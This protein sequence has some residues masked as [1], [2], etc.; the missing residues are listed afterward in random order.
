MSR[1]EIEDYTKSGHVL[2]WPNIRKPQCPDGYYSA[3]C[4]EQK[5]DDPILFIEGDMYIVGIVPV[6]KIGESPLK[7]G[8][9]KQGGLEIVEALRYGLNQNKAD[10]DRP[11]KGNVGL[12]VIDSCDDPQII[13][14]KILTLHRRGANVDGQYIP[15]TEKNT[16]KILGYVGGWSS[17]VSTAVAS[18]TTR[19]NH[20]QISYAS[21]SAELSRRSIFPNFLRIPSSDTKQAETIIDIV[22]T[23]GGNFIQILYSET[24][25]GEGGRD[26]VRALATR[27]SN[28]ICVAKE[29]PVNLHSTPEEIVKEL[30][31]EPGAKFVVTFVASSHIEFVTSFLNNGLKRNEF[32][33][34]ASE[35]W[36]KRP[37][38]TGFTNLVGSIT[39]TSE[40]TLDENFN[41]HLASLRP[42]GSS[43][44]PWVREYMEYINDCYYE[45]SF[46]KI[47]RKP[48]S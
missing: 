36:G 29:I 16:T 32:L 8:S 27:S 26:L 46:N 14:E 12:I 23:L 19:L 20:V 35:G 10:T 33:F 5:E 9:I 24:K 22:K 39:V 45:W 38:M 2:K 4:I 6:H 37:E 28:K 17:D 15:V 13:Q 42:D 25:Y 31:S 40:L 48:C 11:V 47:G 34:I 21:T 43:V 30:R 41:T 1:T 18:L 7:C 3:R 44:D